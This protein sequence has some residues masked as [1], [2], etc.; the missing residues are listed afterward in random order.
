M[1]QEQVVDKYAK[2]R[3]D[4]LSAVSE[5]PRKFTLLDCFCGLGG[6]SNGFVAEGFDVIGI[7][8]EPDIAKIYK[9]KVIVADILKLKGKDFLGYDVIWGSPPCRD[10]STYSYAIWKKGENY[11]NRKWKTPPSS[12]TGLKN[13]YAFLN[14]VRDAE[15]KIWIMENVPELEKFLEIKP[16]LSKVHLTKNMIRS[17][18]GNF[19]FFLIPLADKPKYDEIAHLTKWKEINSVFPCRKVLRSFIY[20]MI[21]EPCSRAF[22]RACKEKLLEMQTI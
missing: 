19:P 18:W 17:F 10:F 1:T 6:V 16:V 13:V 3:E 21:P 22:A 20:A 14:F 8:I 15:P 5:I 9:H 4:V 12:N 11:Q 7:E 2:A